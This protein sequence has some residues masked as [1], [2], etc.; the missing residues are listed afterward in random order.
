MGHFQ[1]SPTKKSILLALFVCAVLTVGS[2][3]GSSKA[4]AATSGPSL[5]DKIYKINYDLGYKAGMGAAKDDK[6]NDH[7]YSPET[8]LANPLIQEFIRTI[9]DQAVEHFGEAYRQDAERGYKDGF[10]AGY[11]E[12]YN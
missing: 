7:S 4:S 12:G 11:K 10:L 6:K 5:H 9:S 3:S 2:D 1:L 8:I